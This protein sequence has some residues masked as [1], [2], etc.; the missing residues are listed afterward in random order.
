MKTRTTFEPSDF[1]G[2][3]QM[4]VRDTFPVGC[5]DYDHGICVAYK[6]C[7]L[8]GEPANDYFLAA[9]SDGMLIK[10]DTI[11]ALCNHLNSDEEGFRPLQRDEMAEIIK[12]HGNRFPC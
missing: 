10:F 8:T 12:R 1:K 2:A 5:K 4:V 9:L 7:W 11:T 3:G 6:V